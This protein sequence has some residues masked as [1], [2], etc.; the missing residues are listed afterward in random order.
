V[1]ISP[2]PRLHFKLHP[3]PLPQALQRTAVAKGLPNT[4]HNH[5]S[6]I[7][8]A[9]PDL[10]IEAVFLTTSSFALYAV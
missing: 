3:R 2:F 9:P 7:N 6:R 8:A 10:P 1:N 4:W 5:H